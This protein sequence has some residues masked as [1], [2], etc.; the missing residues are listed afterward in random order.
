VRV[1]VFSAVSVAVDMVMR[2]RVLEALL[3]TI[4]EILGKIMTIY[5]V[6]M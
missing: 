5:I 3:K 6:A 4:S 2:Y 1:L